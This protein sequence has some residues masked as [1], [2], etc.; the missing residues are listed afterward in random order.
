MADFPR[1]YWYFVIGDLVDFFFFLGIPLTALT[2]YYL[3]KVAKKMKKI[4][5][6]R[7]DAFF[8]SF[9]LTLLIYNLTGLIRGEAARVWLFFMPLAVISSAFFITNYLKK[10]SRIIVFLIA[11]ILL[12]QTLLVEIYFDT[13]W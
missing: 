4:K 6:I 12:I 2:G 1:P 9:I 7:P 13:Y 5:L 11:F 10:Q 3:C 8:L